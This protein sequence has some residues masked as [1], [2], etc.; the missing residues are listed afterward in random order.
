M[1]VLDHIALDEEIIMQ[2]F[3]CDLNACKGACCTMEGGSGAPLREEEIAS[4]E[5]AL[6][7]AARYLSEESQ[8]YIRRH[9]WLAGP[10]G[11]RTVNCIDDKQCVFVVFENS[12]A[13]CAL[14][15]AYFE[16]ESTFRKPI[17]CHLFP[18]RVANFGGPYLYYDRFPECAPAVANGEKLHLRIVDTCHDALVREY[19]E[20]WTDAVQTLD[21]TSSPSA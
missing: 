12:I 21:D 4:V 10:E 7:A 8:E 9:G 15:R 1:I 18:I 11:D 14:E 16:N 13:K 5:Q 6:P 17:S 2:P 20:D 19:G 3:A